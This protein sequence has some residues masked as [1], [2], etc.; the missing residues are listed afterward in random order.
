MV[1][2]VFVLSSNVIAQKNN[3]VKKV[4]IEANKKKAV[5][6]KRTDVKFK[7]SKKKVVAVKTLPDKKVIHHKGQNVYFAN[8]RY[9]SYTGGHYVLTT[10]RVGFRTNILP[11]GYKIIKHNKRNYF[12]H[13]GIFF[14]QYGTEY[15][16]VNPEIGTIVYELPDGYDRVTIDGA[17]YYEYG[18]VLYERIQLNGSRAYEVVGFLEF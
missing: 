1:F 14:V 5:T 3:N 7:S 9:Y 17:T 16:V 13:G 11:V 8:N 15:E 10:P 6:A 18:E 12:F 2:G 4:H